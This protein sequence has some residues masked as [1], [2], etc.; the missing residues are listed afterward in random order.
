M[1][2]VGFWMFPGFLERGLWEGSDKVRP[3]QFGSEGKAGHKRQVFVI[4]AP[5]GQP[6]ALKKQKDHAYAA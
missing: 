3:M 5:A 1:F 4:L 6:P 2:D